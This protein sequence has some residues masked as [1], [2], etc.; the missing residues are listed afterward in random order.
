MHYSRSFD[1]RLAIDLFI[2]IPDCKECRAKI[3]EILR[4]DDDILG[5]IYFGYHCNNFGQPVKVIQAK[6]DVTF[7]LFGYMEKKVEKLRNA[8]FR[9]L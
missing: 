7:D 2:G 8:G 5:E 9:V 3:E 4:A 6:E 1:K